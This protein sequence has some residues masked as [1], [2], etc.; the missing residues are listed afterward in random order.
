MKLGR[1]FEERQTR[2]RIDHVLDQRDEI[3]GHQVRPGRDAV[4][5]VQVSVRLALVIGHCSARIGHRQQVHEAGRFVV[6]VTEDPFGGDNIFELQVERGRGVAFDLL[7][8]KFD[9]TVESDV[10]DFLTSAGVEQHHFPVERASARLI[11]QT[12]VIKV[13]A[14]PSTRWAGTTDLGDGCE[15]LASGLTVGQLVEGVGDALNH[16]LELLFTVGSTHGKVK[17]VQ[18]ANNVSNRLPLVDARWSTNET[19]MADNPPA[20]HRA[21]GSTERRLR[22]PTLSGCCQSASMNGSMKDKDS[23]GQQNIVVDF[24]L[25]SERRFGRNDRR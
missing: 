21:G 7:F 22:T 8:P 17:P 6:K 3:F 11:Q 14:P 18:Q 5:R 16:R 20:G 1:F 25:A 15:V 12:T 23:P 9:E 24:G 4:D 19:L 13:S 10:A 2:M